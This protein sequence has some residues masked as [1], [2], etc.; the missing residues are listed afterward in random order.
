MGKK[1]QG[2]QM[3]RQL[4]LL[5]SFAFLAFAFATFLALAA[6]AITLAL[7]L[8]FQESFAFLSQRSLLPPAL[9]R[10]ANEERPP[11]PAT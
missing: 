5:L 2:F 11:R 7:F 6:F 10:I 9:Q 4:F 1:L 8:L 3:I